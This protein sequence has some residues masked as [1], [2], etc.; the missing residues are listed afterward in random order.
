[1]SLL[2]QVLLLFTLCL[3]LTANF[4]PDVKDYNAYGVKMAANNLIIVQADN[5]LGE[6]L[7]QFAPFT[8]DIDDNY[9]RG[10]LLEYDDVSHYIYT[11]ALGKNQ[12]TY[13][14]FFVGE[15]MDLDEYSRIANRTFVG[16]ISYNGPLDTI[17]CSDF[18]DGDVQ[19]VPYAYPHQEH[20][21]MVTDPPGSVAYVFSNLFTF[22][23]TANTK[24]LV[25]NRTNSL[26]PTSEFLPFAVDYDGT[27]GIIAGFLR[28]NRN[29]RMWKNI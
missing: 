24:R 23:Y 1:M 10:C 22:S 27:R 17:D 19:Y 25:V 7:I 2:L 15:V 9:A 21:V 26:S 4:L 13:N 11:V 16:M 8:D 14:F 18:S 20:L 28:N 29:E 12:S 5:E 3:C 6:F